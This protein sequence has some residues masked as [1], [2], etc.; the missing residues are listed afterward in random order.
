MADEES[1][2]Q[3]SSENLLYRCGKCNT[4]YNFMEGAEKCCEVNA[5]PSESTIV[6]IT[7]KEILDNDC[8]PDYVP[9][10]HDMWSQEDTETLM[11]IIKNNYK[12]LNGKGEKRDTLWNN[13]TEE[14]SKT[15]PGIARKQ[16]ISK[17]KNVKEKFR[18]YEDKKRKNQKVHRP[19]YFDIIE[20]FLEG[21][22]QDHVVECGME[23]V[24]KHEQP[25]IPSQEPEKVYETVLKQTI[26]EI[27]KGKKTVS[28]R[29]QEQIT[30]QSCLDN[31][32]DEEVQQ[33]QEGMETDYPFAHPTSPP[34]NKPSKRIYSGGVEQT[35]VL[36]LKETKR[37][38]AAVELHNAQL[39][40]LFAK[41][42]TSVEVKNKLLK[43]VIE[44]ENV[45]ET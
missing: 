23:T 3:A 11:K 44:K 2:E 31:Y 32:L 29:N 22:P 40:L 4:L 36:F 35:L 10:R 12:R 13:I 21:R 7:K 30:L 16:V 42:A 24:L 5:S 1:E 15:M 14:M 6:T 17:W 41:I 34:I 38:N 27:T 26:S 43:E 25:T 45:M 9:S 28:K 19:D 33:Q 18:K 8:S 37:H 39:R 20:S